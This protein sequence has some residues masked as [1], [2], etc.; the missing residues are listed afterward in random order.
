MQRDEKLERILRD[1]MPERGPQPRAQAGFQ[2]S[3]HDSLELCQELL[4]SMPPTA[5][6]R[7]KKAAEQLIGVWD[8]LKVEAPKDPAVAVGAAFAVFYMAEHIINSREGPIN[9]NMI[10]VVGG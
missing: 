4:R 1:T 8:R 5:Q 7:A 2:D 10:V 3:C 6:K 9:D